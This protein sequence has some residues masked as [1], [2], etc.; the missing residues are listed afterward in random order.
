MDISLKLGIVISIVIA[1]LLAAAFLIPT[2]DER[3]EKAFSD[4]CYELRSNYSC[5][6]DLDFGVKYEK[7]TGDASKYTFLEICRLKLGTGISSI[8]K[9]TKECGCL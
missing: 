3:I 1:A 7:F 4:G 5:S 6:S 2:K 9:C 8:D